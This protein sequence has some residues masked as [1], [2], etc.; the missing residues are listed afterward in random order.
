L[1]RLLAIWSFVIG[2]ILLLFY[3]LVSI[4]LG[5]LGM[6]AGADVVQM[7]LGI[8]ITLVMGGI[9]LIVS[10]IAMFIFGFLAAIV[11]N[12]VL[13]VGGGIDVD[14]RERS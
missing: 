4:L 3:G 9:G 2:V 12:I 14:F 10:A 11:Y 7:L 5:L 6:A 13:G 8:I 1:G